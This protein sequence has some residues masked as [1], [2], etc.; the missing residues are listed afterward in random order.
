MFTQGT[1][2]VL[3]GGGQFCFQRAL[4]VFLVE[5]EGDAAARVLLTHG[6][7]VGS[8]HSGAA[9]LKRREKKRRASERER[10]R[11]R[12]KARKRA[13]SKNRRT[14]KSEGK[15]LRQKKTLKHTTQ[16]PPQNAGFVL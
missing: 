5:R 3:V 6:H 4:K 8:D 9:E 12:E 10:E 11:E 2:L 16:H 14:Q 1:S 7:E 13:V 15:T